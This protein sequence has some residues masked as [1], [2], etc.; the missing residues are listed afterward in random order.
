M[1]LMWVKH[2]GGRRAGELLTLFIS[3]SPFYSYVS[4][5]CLFGDDGEEER[6]GVGGDETCLIREEVK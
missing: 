3:P 4:A 2:F 6:D 5:I 1:G